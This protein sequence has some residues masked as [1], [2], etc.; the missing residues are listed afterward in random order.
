MSDICIGPIDRAT[1]LPIETCG[2]AATKL[3]FFPHESGVAFM[4]PCD[5]HLESVAR[6]AATRFGGCFAGG[7]IAKGAGV[8]AEA[9]AKFDRVD[10]PHGEEFN[11]LV[12]VA[13]PPRDFR[14]RLGRR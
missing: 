13:G 6:W 14:R 3:L 1:D 10:T 9:A 5:R 8:M 4:Y 11:A 7:P 12:K 2:E